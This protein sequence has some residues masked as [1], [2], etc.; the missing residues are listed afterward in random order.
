MSMGGG[1]QKEPRSAKE[2]RK[3][4]LMDLADLDEDENRKIKALFRARMGGRAFRSPTS[5]RTSGNSAGGGSLIPAS[6]FGGTPRSGG[7][8]GGGTRSVL[9]R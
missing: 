5:A 3:R 9:V 4:Q 2:L 8:G 1:G 6:G 7:G